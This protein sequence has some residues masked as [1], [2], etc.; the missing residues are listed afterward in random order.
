[1]SESDPAMISQ[2]DPSRRKGFV[3]L[4]VSAIMTGYYLLSTKY[5]SIA[6]SFREQVDTHGLTPVAL[7]KTDPA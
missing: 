7:F 4:I 5:Y 6:D 3:F 1:M 2:N